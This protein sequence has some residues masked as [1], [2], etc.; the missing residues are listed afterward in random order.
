MFL[1]IL[2]VSLNLRK[3]IKKIFLNCEVYKCM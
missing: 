3:I 2:S 1:Y